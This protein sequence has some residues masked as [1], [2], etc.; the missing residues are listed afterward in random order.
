VYSEQTVITGRRFQNYTEPESMG[1]VTNTTY[2]RCFWPVSTLP[3]E[4]FAPGSSGII[5]IGPPT[6]RNILFPDDTQFGSLTRGD[7]FFDGADDPE[8]NGKKLDPAI[9]ENRVE[10]NK[11]DAKKIK[12][13]KNP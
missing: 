7:C 9:P 8:H 1:V 12:K 11:Q 3:V 5:V 6:P 4:L 13:P 2:V 10:I